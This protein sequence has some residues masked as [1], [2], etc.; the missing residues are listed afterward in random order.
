MLWA[1][2][3]KAQARIQNQ[4]LSRAQARERRADG[5]RYK[6]PKTPIQDRAHGARIAAE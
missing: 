1:R 3:R 6:N 2:D 5:E 4:T